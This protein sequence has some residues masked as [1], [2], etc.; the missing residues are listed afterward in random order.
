[1]PIMDGIT[2]TRRINDI[3]ARDNLCAND[4][5]TVTIAC[6]AACAALHILSQA[7]SLFFVLLCHH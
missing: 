4:G 1:M 5:A 7:K 6:A 2:A 3:I